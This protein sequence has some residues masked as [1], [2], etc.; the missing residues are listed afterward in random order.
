MSDLFGNHIVG[1]LTPKLKYH[2]VSMT[3]QTSTGITKKRKKKKNIFRLAIF[4]HVTT[5][6]N[7]RFTHAVFY[8]Q[9]LLPYVGDIG[10]NDIG[11]IVG[12]IGT[13]GITSGTVGKT[14][15]EFCLLL[16]TRGPMVL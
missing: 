12:T 6:R 15:N 9:Y 14:L 3:M 5:S 2:H 16:L 8:L 11:T 1:L 4:N 10:T 13:N 7:G